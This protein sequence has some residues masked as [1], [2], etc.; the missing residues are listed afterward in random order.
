MCRDVDGGSGGSNGQNGLNGLNGLDATVSVGA[1]STTSY[2]NP[3]IITNTGTSTN[4]VFNFTI[5]EGAPGANGTN[6]TNGIDAVEGFTN[7]TINH[8]QS[9]WIAGVATTMTLNNSGYGLVGGFNGP[10]VPAL[11]DSF[12]TIEFQIVPGTYTLSVITSRLSNR[13]LITWYLDSSVLSFGTTDCYLNGTDTI[14][15]SIAGVV[16]PSSTNNSHT[17][18]A[19]VSKHVSSTGYYI[20]LGN[21][22]FK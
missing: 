4:A 14:V 6:G 1:T 18:R 10:G 20:F 7:T 2:G 9:T 13:G 21:I 11:N 5:P 17:L 19:V 8:V 12:R 3:P 22:W 16:I 15:Q